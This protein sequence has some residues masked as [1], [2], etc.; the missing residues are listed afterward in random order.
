MRMCSKC[1]LIQEST[2]KNALLNRLKSPN[3]LRNIMQNSD[4]DIEGCYKLISGFF[5]QK[6]SGK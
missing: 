5:E 6:R 3:R 4:I 2:R 1:V